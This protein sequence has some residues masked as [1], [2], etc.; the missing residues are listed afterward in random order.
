VLPYARAPHIYFGF[1]KRFVPGRNLTKHATDG[2]SDAVF[3]TSRDGANFHRFAEALIRPGPQ[4]DNWVSRNTLPAWGMVMT[5]SEFPEAPDEIS[6]YA[7]ESYYSGK[8][9]RLRRFSIRQDGFV[10]VQAPAEGGEMLTRPFVFGDAENPQGKLALTINFA[11]SAAGTIRCELQDQAGQ[12]LEGFALADCD[13]IYGDELKR[14]VTWRG[15]ADVSALAG[16]TIRVRF[17][18][19]DADLFALQFQGSRSQGP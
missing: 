8:S 2:A 3:M 4:R 9:C 19:N 18:M 17:V 12:P 7:T 5:P 13:A 15:K 1:P 10:S 6:I 14:E 16:E 11:T